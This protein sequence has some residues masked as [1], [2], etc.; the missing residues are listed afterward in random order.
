MSVPSS[1]GINSGKYNRHHACLSGIMDAS[2]QPHRTDHAYARRRRATQR[3]ADNKRLKCINVE[4]K[5]TL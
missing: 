3:I 2:F 4:Y 5:R 1:G